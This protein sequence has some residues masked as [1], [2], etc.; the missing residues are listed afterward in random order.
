MTWTPANRIHN[1]SCCE[2]CKEEGVAYEWKRWSKRWSESDSLTL[3]RELKTFLS[4][5]ARKKS[6]EFIS[7]ETRD[8]ARDL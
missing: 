5:E 4:A 3:L 1:P 7:C 2:G 8:L 6:S